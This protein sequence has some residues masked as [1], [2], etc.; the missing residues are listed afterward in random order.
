MV[1]C[2]LTKVGSCD[3]SDSSNSR[4]S[5]PEGEKNGDEKRNFEL[6]SRQSNGGPM[7][8]V[9]KCTISQDTKVDIPT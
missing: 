9:G 7:M 8:K 3:L 2:L 4:T 1:E 6:A 5:S